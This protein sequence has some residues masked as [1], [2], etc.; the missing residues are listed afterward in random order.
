MIYGRFIE[1]DSVGFCRE[2]RFLSRAANRERTRFRTDCLLIEPSDGAE[3]M[4]RGVTTDG[5]RL[6][7][8]DPLSVRIDPGLYRIV[9]AGKRKSWLAGIDGED[10]APEAF[11][12]YRKVMPQEP[13]DFTGELKASKFYKNKLIDF[14][15]QFPEPAYLDFAYVFDLTVAD[16]E[17]EWEVYWKN[18]ISAALL[19]KSGCYTAVVMPLRA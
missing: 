17:I 1:S 7:I 8:V 13:W 18:S 2:I 3:G 11:P 5:R 15:R 16:I 19:F 10:N 14:F 9:K 4:S 6:H 12:A